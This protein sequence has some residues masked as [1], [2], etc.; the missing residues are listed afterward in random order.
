MI[1][2]NQIRI[3]K[4]SH[5]PVDLGL[6]TGGGGGGDVGRVG[7]NSIQVIRLRRLLTLFCFRLTVSPLQNTSRKIVKHKKKVKLIFQKSNVRSH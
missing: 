6:S 5:L 7:R 3:K 2:F 4:C 1:P